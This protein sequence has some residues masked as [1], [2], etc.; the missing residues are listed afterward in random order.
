MSRINWLDSETD[1]PVLQQKLQEL[2]H[3]TDAMADGVIDADELQTSSEKLNEALKAA[4]E[5][6]NDEQHALVTD[7]LVELSAHTIMNTL[8]QIAAQRQMGAA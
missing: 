7:L 6:L 3:F 5:T 4:Q 2:K 1:T 8:H